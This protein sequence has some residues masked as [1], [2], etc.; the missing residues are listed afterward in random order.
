M[1]VASLVST[2]VISLFIIMVLGYLARSFGV[3]SGKGTVALEKLLI[4]VTNP[5]LIFIAFQSQSGTGRLGA[6]ATV[7]GASAVI[8]IGTTV[9]AMLIFRNKPLKQANTLRFCLIFSNCGF[10]GYP[11]LR[12]A[13]PA[14][15]M[16]YGACYVLFFTVYMW[17]LGV[18]LLSSGKK[19]TTGTCLRKAVLN[20]GV[21][22]AVLGL[23]FCLMGIRLPSAL[24][25]ALDSTAEITFPLAMIILG[26]MLRSA[27]IGKLLGNGGVYLV[28]I[29][30]NI[31]LP[32]LVLLIC[33]LFKVADGTTYV[34]VIMASTPVA[35]KAPILAETYGADR[36]SALSA[37]AISTLCSLV[38]IPAVLYITR[39]VLGV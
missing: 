33:R 18:F 32:L 4:Y 22:A 3:I 30:K 20:P 21:I 6:M 8:H 19:G 7:I 10:M 17:T 12:A 25:S 11:L 38:S 1:N 2:Q 34:C 14:N 23:I 13:F 24:F 39:M 26:S 37:V 5:L 27:P 31:V 15:G 36:T 28:T 35:A 29:A 9:L 16:F